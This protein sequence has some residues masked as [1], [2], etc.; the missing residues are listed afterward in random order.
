MNTEYVFAAVI[1]KIE[2]VQFESRYNIERLTLGQSPG[3]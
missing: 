1:F 2:L 3:G